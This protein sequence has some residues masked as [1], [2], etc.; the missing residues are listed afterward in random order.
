MEE[1]PAAATSSIRDVLLRAEQGLARDDDDPLIVGSCG[2]GRKL[3]V[4]FLGGLA[5]NDSEAAV[6]EFED[7]GARLASGAAAL[8]WCSP[9]T[10][11]D[12][13]GVVPTLWLGLM[14]A[15]EPRVLGA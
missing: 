2:V 11:H 6:T 15:S 3:G 10:S 4:E 1:F 8:A 12:F 9:D 5:P 13:H 7:V 14:G